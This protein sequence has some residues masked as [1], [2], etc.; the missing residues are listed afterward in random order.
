MSVTKPGPHAD[1]PEG[2]PWLGRPIDARPLSGPEVA[3]FLDLLRALRP[4]EWDR[5]AVPGWT[6][7]DLAAHVLGDFHGRLGRRPDGFRPVVAPG[8]TLEAFVHRVNQDWVDLHAG[9]GPAGLVEAL[10]AAGPQVVRRFEGADLDA[11]GLGVSWAGWPPAGSCPSSTDA[12]APPAP[13]PPG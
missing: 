3:A 4:G 1:R 5:A 12:P 6:V 11:I 7:R 10:A 9:V 8:E 13:R 2:L